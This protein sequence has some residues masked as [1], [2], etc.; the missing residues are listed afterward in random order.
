M[1]LFQSKDTLESLFFA[2]LCSQKHCE[3]SSFDD[4]R[5]ILLDA[6][7]PLNKS[8]G[9]FDSYL[10]V[11]KNTQSCNATYTSRSLRKQTVSFE[12]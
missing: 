10:H 11:L 6:R 9:Q 8:F 2:G 4:T 12:S 1:T 3:T 7:R 5:Q